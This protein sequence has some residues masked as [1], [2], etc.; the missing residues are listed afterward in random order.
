MNMEIEHYK[1]KI[2]CLEERV[3]ELEKSN[4][5]LNESLR[6]QIQFSAKLSN[7]IF[8]MDCL[9]AKKSN[10][11]ANFEIEL[12]N[13]LPNNAEAIDHFKEVDLGSNQGQIIETVIAPTSVVINVEDFTIDLAEVDEGSNQMSGEDTKSPSVDVNEYVI[14]HHVKK[15]KIM[16]NPDGVYECP[17]DI[18]G[19]K[20]SYK[21]SKYDDMNRHYRTHSNE[22]PFECKLCSRAF[23]LKSTCI[24]H[25]R[26]HDDNLKLQ[27]SVCTQLFTHPH[28]LLKHTAKYHNGEGY[29]RKKRPSKKEPFSTAKK[30]RI[31]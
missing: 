24:Q 11:I 26:T 9:L 21:T 30:R 15:I 18:N 1:S 22:K 14:Q 27:C 5:N 4:I 28:T 8:D 19:V 25:I 31:Q 7:I 17:D 2:E 12:K 20:C 29:Q 3:L 13:A 23:T 10:E 6:K 16:S